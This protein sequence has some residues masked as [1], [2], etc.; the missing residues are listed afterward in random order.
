M[1]ILCPHRTMHGI[2]YLILLLG[3]HTYAFKSFSRSAVGTYR[4]II[5]LESA[6]TPQYDFPHFGQT[7]I[8]IFALSFIKHPPD[9]LQSAF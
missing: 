3:F 4:R 9:P 2:Q 7:L 8:L 1:Y 6:G 5:A